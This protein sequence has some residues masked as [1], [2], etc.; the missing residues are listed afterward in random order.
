MK[1]AIQN[2]ILGKK[3]E[4]P[5]LLETINDNASIKIIA[6]QEITT[7]ELAKEIK[8]TFRSLVSKTK[9]I[10]L[11]ISKIQIIESYIYLT[12]LDIAFASKKYGIGFKIIIDENNKNC[13]ERYIY[14]DKKH[15]NCDL[16]L[17]KLENIIN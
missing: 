4:T 16:C 1:D 7:I 5:F 3:T 8:K 11:D 12:I 17:A 14:R 15:F 6:N 9:L 10:V 13:K 2:I